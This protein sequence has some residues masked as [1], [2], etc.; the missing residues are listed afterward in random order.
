MINKFT[1]ND[2][3]VATWPYIQYKMILSVF[4]EAG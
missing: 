4:Q 1:D 2:Q 3:Y